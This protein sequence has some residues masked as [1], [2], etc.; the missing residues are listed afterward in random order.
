VRQWCR[1][2]E[3]VARG[4]VRA[5]AGALRAAL[6]A[7]A[8]ADAEPLAARCR[9]ALLRR[10][11][12]QIAPA[13]AR[14]ERSNGHSSLPPPRESRPA[15]RRTSRV[16]PPPPPPPR[17]PIPDAPVA[18]NDDALFAETEPL[19]HQGN[20]S[21]V[22]ELLGDRPSEAPPLSARLSLL[23]AIALKEAQASAGRGKQSADADLLGMRAVSALLRVPDESPTA[24]IVGKRLLRKR[25]IEWQNAPP[26]RV[27]LLLTAIALFVG[28][29]VG[30]LF[31]QRL[32]DLIW[33]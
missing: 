28:A 25:P 9:R 1:D 2:L 4:D 21:G 19:L 14:S 24:L 15:A 6:E 16:T 8:P 12:E 11:L 23:Y 13:D 5:N 17:S 33:K 27:S 3:S 31:N 10:R 22:V 32:I 29:A 7:A 26:R 18:D 20:W 30:L